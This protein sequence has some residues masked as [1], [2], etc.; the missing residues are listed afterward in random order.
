MMPRGAKMT[1]FFKL[2]LS[3]SA[4]YAS[5]WLTWRNHAFPSRRKQAPKNTSDANR[6]VLRGIGRSSLPSN[7]CTSKFGKLL[8]SRNI[9]SGAI[10]CRAD[11]CL[12]RIHCLKRFLIQIGLSY[13]KERAQNTSHVFPVPTESRRLRNGSKIA[14]AREKTK[15]G[16]GKG[17]L[18]GAP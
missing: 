7:C 6:S 9:S 2:F 3:L 11:A 12:F 10:S 14:A 4:E 16:S 5:P 8:A 18:S 17:K 13:D 1:V 15:K